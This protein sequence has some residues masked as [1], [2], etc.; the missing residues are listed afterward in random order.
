MY[1]TQIVVLVAIN[2]LLALG[3][4]LPFS[5]GVLVMCVGSFMGTGAIA[6]AIFHSQFNLPFGVALIAGAVCSATLGFLIGVICCKLEGF[7][8]AVATL[9]IGE[10]LRVVVINSPRLG[11]ALGY[12]DVEFLPS[13]AYPIAALVIVIC[14]V[15]VFERSL[16]RRALLVVRA[17]ELAA[18]SMGISVVHSRVWSVVASAFIGGLAGGL[19]IHS[20]GILD[21][22]LFGFKKSVEV[23]MYAVAGGSFGLWGTLLSSLVLTAVPELLRFSEALRM[24]LY[25]ICIVLLV[26]LRPEGIL[27]VRRLVSLLELGREVRGV[28]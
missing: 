25:G 1:Y 3:A 15:I 20:V 6:A 11:G 7:S 24:I 10:A 5:S 27:G 12:R 28:R 16:P 19:Y 17:N 4:Y 8:F 18:S 26:V 21:P 13:A 14:G 2:A 23:I 22:H 9:G